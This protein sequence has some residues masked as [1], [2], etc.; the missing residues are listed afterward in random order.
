MAEAYIHQGKDAGNAIMKAKGNG[1]DDSTEAI[2]QHLDKLAESL[3]QKNKETSSA[4]EKSPTM[5]F[6]SML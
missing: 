6:E 5:R 3:V 1:F 4:K 2:N